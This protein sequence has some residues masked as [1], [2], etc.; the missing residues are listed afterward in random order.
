[1]IENL[2]TFIC[3]G[4]VDI[5]K[6]SSILKYKKVVAGSIYPYYRKG[7]FCDIDDENDLEYA[8]YLINKGHN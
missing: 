5:S 7:Y 3:D 6:I 2:T 4:Y 8:E 1:M